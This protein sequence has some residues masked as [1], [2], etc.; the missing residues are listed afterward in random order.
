MSTG[1]VRLRAASQRAAD[2]QN[3]EPDP[4]QQ[5]GDADDHAEERKLLGHVARIERGG[6]RG[7]SDPDVASAVGDR[8]LGLR[9]D[10]GVLGVVGA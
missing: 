1:L 8:L 4:A 9:V 10:Q 2:G 3:R 5:Q 7:L 6:E